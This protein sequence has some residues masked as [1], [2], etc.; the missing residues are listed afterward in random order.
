MSGLRVLTTVIQ[1]LLGGTA[2]YLV[3]WCAHDF[4]RSHREDEE[5]W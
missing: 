4:R 2:L 1:I 5:E 3:A